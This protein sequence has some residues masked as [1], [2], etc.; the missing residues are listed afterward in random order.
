MGERENWERM[1]KVKSRN[2]CK[3]LMHKDTGGGEED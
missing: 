2:K 1:E 3:G